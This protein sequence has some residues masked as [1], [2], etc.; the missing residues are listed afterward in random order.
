MQ[1]IVDYCQRYLRLFSQLYSSV[2]FVTLLSS[3]TRKIPPEISATSTLASLS[4]DLR[5]FG[6]DTCLG[7]EIIP[8]LSDWYLHH[9]MPDFEFGFLSG[10]DVGDSGYTFRL[11]IGVDNS[12]RCPM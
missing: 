5:Y 6:G 8:P 2:E 9:F 7:V 4:M 12:K 11:P 3:Y 10:G 1:R